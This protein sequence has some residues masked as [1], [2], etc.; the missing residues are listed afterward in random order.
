MIKIYC[1]TNLDLCHCE[2]WPTELPEVPRVGDLIESSYE[3]IIPN[4]NT[5]SSGA[6]VSL[7]LQVCRV[8]W[9]AHAYGKN[10]YTGAKDGTEWIPHVELSMTPSRYSSMRDFYEWYGRITGKGVHT[11]I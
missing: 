10:Q 11:F 3:W 2:G 1:H 9:K 6:K 8:T 5:I 4:G 7:E